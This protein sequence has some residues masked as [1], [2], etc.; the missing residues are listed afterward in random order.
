[1]KKILIPPVF[2]LLGLLLI[3]SFYFIFPH[4][5]YIPFPVNLIGIVFM[6]FGFLMN[7]EAWE[8]LKK[9]ETPHSFEKSVVLVNEGIFKKTRNPMYIGMFLLLLGSASCFGN[10]IS[11]LIPFLFLVI[12]RIIFIPFEEKMLEEIFGKQYQE[13]KKQ[14][15]R[16]I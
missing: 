7:S 14:V 2:V 1:M 12:V 15:R 11:I 6:F 10:L 4:L 16:W 5:N 8:L 3:I 9:Y 13:Y